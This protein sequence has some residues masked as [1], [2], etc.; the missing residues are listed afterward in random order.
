MKLVIDIAELVVTVG[1][2]FYLQNVL[3]SRASDDRVEKDVALECLHKLRRRADQ[4]ADALAD[5]SEDVDIRTKAGEILLQ[6][7]ALN[8]DLHEL[9]AML[10]ETPIRV[11]VGRARG[12]RA[13]LFNIKRQLTRGTFPEQ[14]DPDAA[15]ASVRRLRDF[16]RKCLRLVCYINRL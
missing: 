5:T 11:E 4:F 10:E 1:V 2:L 16:Q 7:R 9:V 15:R 8:N 13:D 14:I 3:S 12:L 6:L